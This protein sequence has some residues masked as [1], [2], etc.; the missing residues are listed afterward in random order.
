MTI[1]T[2]A[3]E[4]SEAF[5]TLDRNGETIYVLRDGS[6]PWMTDVAH[7]AHGDMIPDDYRYEFVY[8]AVSALENS[9]DVDDA[10]D[11]IEAD[12][13]TTGLTK[14]LHSRVDRTFYMSQAIEDGLTDGKDSSQHLMTAQWLE[15]MEVF[16]AVVV[17]LEKRLEELEED[18]RAMFSVIEY[19]SFYAVRHN[20]TGREH[21]MG[22]GVDAV[23]DHNDNPIPAGDPRLIPVWEA[24][25][26]ADEDETLAAYF[27]DDDDD[28]E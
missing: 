28:D 24:Y 3:A 16:D 18:D 5:T 6:P 2:L 27:P 19:G 10:R 7:A 12:V 21:P 13:Y 20:P 14:W 4:M 25:L 15:K 22:D 26:N 23:F 11:S 1:F 17:A 9:E 8:D